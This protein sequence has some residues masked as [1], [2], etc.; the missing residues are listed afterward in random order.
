[1]AELQQFFYLLFTAN[2]VSS[3][4]IS[5]Q[6]KSPGRLQSRTKQ[7]MWD[8]APGGT[9]RCSSC[10]RQ[11]RSPVL[12]HIPSSCCP[13]VE[14]ALHRSQVT[15][16]WLL[17]SPEGNALP[18]TAGTAG[19]AR[20]QCFKYTSCVLSIHVTCKYLH[21]AR[22]STWRNSLVRPPTHGNDAAL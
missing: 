4:H 20:Q 11:S 8:M 16:I 7:E 15:D 12:G 19:T 9:G 17:Q 18:H 6:V 5:T 21:H 22:V 1:M 13:Q 3:S 10:R 14:G 2:I